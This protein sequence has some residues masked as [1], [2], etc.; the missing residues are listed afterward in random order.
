MPFPPLL[1][2]SLFLISLDIL[3]S[4]THC[5]SSYPVLPSVFL[6]FYAVFLTSQVEFQFIIAAIAMITFN[7]PNRK[8][9]AERKIDKKYNK[10]HQ[11][12]QFVQ[13]LSISLNKFYVIFSFATVPHLFCSCT[14]GNNKNK[15]LTLHYRTSQPHSFAL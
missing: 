14:N 9:G 7:R 8:S 11:I 12:M 1:Y 2:T 3:L 15:P 10:I 4:Y 13:S 6:H 5:T